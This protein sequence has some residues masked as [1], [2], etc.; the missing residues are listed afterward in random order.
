[1][2]EG[3]YYRDINLWVEFVGD[4]EIEKRGVLLENVTQSFVGNLRAV[5]N[6]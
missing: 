6:D 2:S 3:A 1:V 4:V 5:G